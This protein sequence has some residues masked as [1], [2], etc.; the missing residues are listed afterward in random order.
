MKPVLLARSNN[1]SVYT[2]IVYPDF[3]IHDL[4]SKPTIAP[5]HG[6]DVDVSSM[7]T[8]TVNIIPTDIVRS[9]IGTQYTIV[10][11]RKHVQIAL[12]D[13][14]IHHVTRACCGRCAYVG[15]T[16]QIVDNVDELLWRLYAALMTVLFFHTKKLILCSV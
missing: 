12:T 11:S 16:W 13:I 3:I 2:R 8:L 5:Y 15:S 1:C 14:I 6:F 9:I 10:S 7:C 4:N